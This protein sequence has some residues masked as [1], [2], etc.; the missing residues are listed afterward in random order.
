MLAELLFLSRQDLIGLGLTI[1]DVIA[2]VEDAVLQQSRNQ[3]N[4]PDKVALY[5]ERNRAL[6]GMPAYV[7]SQGALGIKWVGSVPANN[8][9]DLPQTSGLIILNDPQTAFPT[10]VIDGTWITAMRTGAISA[11]TARHLAPSQVRVLGLVG[12]G[13]QM[14]TQLLALNT[15]LKPERIQVYDTRPAAMDAFVAQM[16]TLVDTPLEPCGTAQS[17]VEGA[18]VVVSATWLLTPPDPIIRAAWIKPGAL[19]MPIDVDSIW[20]PAAYL[21]ADKFITDRWGPIEHLGEIGG[22][23]GGLP[24]LHAELHELVGGTRPGRE[25]DDEYIV[26]MNTGMAIDDIPLAKLAF[27][28]A[29]AGGIGTRLPFITSAEEVFQF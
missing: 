17:A 5:Y 15:V 26:A 13:V 7:A 28:R 2:V 21:N 27:D 9:R 16:S 23:P 8:E 25:S 3:V 12:C 18:D 1:Q 10:A 20:E 14:R 11:I 6:H 29:V 24:T 4:M 22:F 19:A